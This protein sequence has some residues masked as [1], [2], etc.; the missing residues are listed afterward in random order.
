MT[1]PMKDE[2]LHET[3]RIMGRLV[4]TPPDHKTGKGKA[5]VAPDG[6]KDSEGAPKDC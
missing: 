2:D 4:K 6:S 5:A 1:D 3:K